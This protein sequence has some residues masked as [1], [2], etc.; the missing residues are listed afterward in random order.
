MA[1]YSYNRYES[2]GQSEFAITFDYLS[3]DHID[4]YLDSVEQTTG[5]AIDAGTNKVTFTSA[6]SSGTVVLIKRVT[7]KTKAEYQSQIADFQDGSVL[8][9][10]DLD[11]AVLG[12]LFISQEAEDSATSDALGLDQLDQNWTA[13]SKRIK[14]VGTPT[15]GTDAV[16]KEY[17]DGLE[18]Y[19]SPSVPQL[20]SFTATASQTD[21]VLSPAPTSTDV[22]SFIVDL[23]GVVQKPTTDFTI[24]GSTLTLVTGA[25]VDH[26]LTVRNIGVTRDIISDSASTTGDFSVGDDLT[27]T[28]DA[29][30]GGDLAV[31]GDLTVTGAVAGNV[32]STGSDTARNLADR[33]A[34]RYNILD[35]AVGGYA[36]STSF[37]TGITIDATP[38]FNAA[39]SAIDTAGG[40]ILYI[41]Q[42][43]YHFTTRPNKLTGGVSIDGDYFL[44]TTLV[45]RYDESG[46][47]GLIALDG[48]N[49]NNTRIE[50]L[51]L[52]NYSDNYTGTVHTDANHV[53]NGCGISIVA[54]DDSAAPGNIFINNIHASAEGLGGS[55][56]RY[57]KSCIYIDGSLKATPAI[58]V[59]GVWI[60]NCS[61]FA[62]ATAALEIYGTQHLFCSLVESNVDRPGATGVLMDGGLESSGGADN[63]IVSDRPVFVGCDFQSVGGYSFGTQPTTHGNVH[64]AHVFGNLGDLQVGTGCTS[65]VFMGILG[66]GASVVPATT[67][68]YTLLTDDQSHIHG[69]LTVSGSGVPLGGFATGSTTPPV[70]G[71]H[72]VGNAIVGIEYVTGSTSEAVFS[73]GSS[74]PGVSSVTVEA[75]KTCT[76]TLG[77]SKLFV[78]SIATGQA[79]LVFTD[80][81]SGTVN[82]LA[83]PSSSFTTASSTKTRITCAVDSHNVVLTNESGGQLRYSICTLGNNPSA[84][85]VTT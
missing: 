11:T 58:G 18:L 29:S 20:Y 77:S 51:S 22:R 4:V 41:P 38:T 59:R 85:V 8:T 30:V 32:T 2:T 54:D 31:T 43:Y 65:P 16:T 63:G 3:T 66:S 57:W 44:K 64:G 79:A 36:P 25:T 75:T 10:S 49:N 83:D 17:V 55:V 80:L 14:M 37:S 19:N 84:V 40:G 70:D 27:V 74:A 69:G 53:G 5:F 33:F 78:I 76:I 68:S 81:K 13:E 34:E 61:I 50:N 24:S 56:Y 12:L 62:Q 26:V 46:N 52:Y 9:E 42:G 72:A 73:A 39:I 28:D 23:E 21:F 1:I 6:P 7:P 48:A 35:F 82:I 60:T 71:I 45:K 15:G 47:R 67:D